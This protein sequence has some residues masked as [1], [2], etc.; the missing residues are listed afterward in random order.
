MFTEPSVI[1]FK[2]FLVQ[3]PFMIPNPR[4]KYEAS[5][6][7]KLTTYEHVIKWH[8]QEHI[9]IIKILSQEYP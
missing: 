3:I 9:G 7:I 4:Y 6:I 1:S 2:L 8:Y 5:V